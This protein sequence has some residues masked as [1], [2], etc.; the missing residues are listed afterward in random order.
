MVPDAFLNQLELKGAEVRLEMR[1]TQSEMARVRMGLAKAHFSL[2]EAVRILF[3][4]DG[5]GPA[6]L[7]LAQI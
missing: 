3:L 7:Q 2:K 1:R 5:I 4:P 6:V